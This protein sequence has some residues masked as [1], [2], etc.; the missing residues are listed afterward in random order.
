MK[1]FAIF[2]LLSTL[3][4]S[5]QGAIL[6]EEGFSGL[7][8]GTALNGSSGWTASSAMEVVDYSWSSWSNYSSIAD[9]A[10]RNDST[11]PGRQASKA[12]S[13]SISAGS[14][15]TVYMSLT[16]N[17]DDANAGW[18]NFM[19][20]NSSSGTTSSD[21]NNAFAQYNGSS[22]DILNSNFGNNT[23]TD[24]DGDF[25]IVAAMTFGAGANGALGQLSV[26]APGEDAS[27]V[28][29]GFESSANS[30]ISGNVDQFLGRLNDFTTFGNV[31][32]GTSLSEVGVIPEP[33]TAALLGLAALMLSLRL[34]R[35][36]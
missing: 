2:P 28:Y 34:R 12:L 11:G 6:L 26:F 15:E 23:D 27:A 8:N 33:S 14:G 1:A 21:V 17:G 30:E 31:R 3:L 32:V 13:G 25:L 24:R 29:S 36:R 18:F 22:F 16:F 9:K 19:L 7:A 35:Q 10:V 20:R 5:V 4:I